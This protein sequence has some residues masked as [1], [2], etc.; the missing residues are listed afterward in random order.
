MF[1][2][3]RGEAAEEAAANIVQHKI[4]IRGG[5]ELRIE[6]RDKLFERC[7]LNSMKCAE[8]GKMHFPTLRWDI[9]YASFY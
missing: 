7:A 8:S 6:V 1:S 2:H 4:S 5:K 3:D 9:F